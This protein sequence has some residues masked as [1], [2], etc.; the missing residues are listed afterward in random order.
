MARSGLWLDRMH[1]KFHLLSL[2][3]ATNP[4]IILIPKELVA[5]WV[6]HHSLRLHVLFNRKN[7][8]GYPDGETVFKTTTPPLAETTKR[9]TVKT[10]RNYGPGL[11]TPQIIS[12]PAKLNL[13]VSNPSP[14]Q[15]TVRIPPYL[16]EPIKALIYTDYLH[17]DPS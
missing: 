13:L 7:N 2:L 12:R 1:L 8:W 16:P 6:K 17:T 3:L 4:T 15:P 11:P 14:N 5:W 10:P 9:N